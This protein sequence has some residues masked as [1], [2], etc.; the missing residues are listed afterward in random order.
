MTHEH[1]HAEEMY[2]IKFDEYVKDAPIKGT[3]FPDDFTNENL[4]RS[5]KREL[6]VYEKMMKIADQRKFTQFEMIN[7]SYN[8]DLYILLLRKRGINIKL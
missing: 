8:V 3:E 2:K 1:F 4:L 6:Y 7:I 5:Y